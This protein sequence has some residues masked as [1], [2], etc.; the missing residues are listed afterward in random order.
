M[1]HSIRGYL[2]RRTNKELEEILKNA[3]G[4][5]DLWDRETIIKMILEIK[6]KREKQKK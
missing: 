2:E 1:D 5:T 3:S 6:E 4:Q